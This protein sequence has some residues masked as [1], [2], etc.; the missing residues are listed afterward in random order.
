MSTN[1]VE[2]VGPIAQIVHFYCEVK[3]S[4]SLY[5]NKK[6]ND[7]VLA[8]QKRTA[9]EI[10]RDLWR[11]KLHHKPDLGIFHPS[12]GL[13]KAMIEGAKKWGV[14][15][16]GKNRSKYNTAFQSAITMISDFVV[17]DE[18]WK[19]IGF[20]SPL[21]KSDERQVTK[22]DGGQVLVVTP[23][24]DPPWNAKFVV[25]VH[26]PVF[27]GTVIATMLRYAGLYNGIGSWWK[28]WG[29]FEPTKVEETDIN[30]Y[31]NL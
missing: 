16:P 28:K 8:Q 18:K 30:A 9:D 27:N 15:I 14:S 31:S 13:T 12:D 23:R 20:E 5:W 17:C 21:L 29:R 2:K 22:K 24:L 6:L 25:T 19:H 10:Q 3:G 1:F 26:D 4:T 11:H 7:D